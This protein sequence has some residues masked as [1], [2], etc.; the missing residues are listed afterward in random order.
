VP[1]L[2]LPKCSTGIKGFDEIT[3]GGL[4]KGR[5]TLICGGAGC[6]KTVFSMEYLVRGASEY[7]EPG[8]FMSFEES[9]KDLLENFSTDGFRLKELIAEN[10]IAIDHVFVDRKE[11]EETGEYDLEGLFIRLNMAIDQVKAKRVVLDTIESLFSGF[12]NEGILRAELR[13]LFRWLKDK[14]VTAVITAERGKDTFTRHGLEEYVADCVILLDHRVQGQL[15]TRRL[16]IVK[17]RGSV[18][19]SDEYPFLIHSDGLSLVPI[20]TLSLNQAAPSERAST[21]VDRLDTMLDGKGYYRG[22]TILVSGTA[23]T[24]KTSLAA[25]FVDSTCSRGERAVYLSFEESPAQIVRNMKSIGIDLEGWVKKGLIQFHAVRPTLYGLESHLREIHEII[26]TFQPDA[27]VIDPISNLG[28][29]GNLTEVKSMMVRVLDYLKSRGITTLCTDLTS[30]GT[31]VQETEIGISSLSDTW[32]LLRI[33][34]N[35]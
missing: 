15:S 13:R 34:E 26:E 9:E 30:G 5:P 10:K 33:H 3:G 20:S 17:Y 24:G 29:I 28:S 21:G 7:G 19:G 31:S 35:L 14:G 22:S 25:Q 23:G 8:V 11:I 18:H 32:I 6:G 4:P 27:V 12:S 2:T 1:S 16:R